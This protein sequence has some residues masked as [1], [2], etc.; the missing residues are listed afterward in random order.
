[1]TKMAT[2]RQTWALFCITKKDYRN[3][4][5]TYDQASALIK[6]LGD[7]NYVKK[8]KVVKDNEAI[9]IMQEAVTAG[10]AALTACTPV[11]MVVQQHASVL[12][13]NSPVV[14]EWVVDGG[15]CGFAWI[16][17]KA[18]TTPNRKFLAGLKSAGLVGDNGWGKATG[19]GY[20][21]WVHQ[22]GQSMTKKEAFAHAFADVLRVNDITAYA[23]SRM[24]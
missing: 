18:N 10:M 24:D 2:K 8:S 11:P 23:Q 3:E 9:R 16:T 6:E 20:S 5:L 12:N 1:M 22:G 14:Q 13:D 4:N 15:V 7:P 17:F 21:Y 19:G